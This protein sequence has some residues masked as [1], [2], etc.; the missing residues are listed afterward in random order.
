MA[1]YT[2]NIYRSNLDS[3]SEWLYKNLNADIDNLCKTNVMH[4]CKQ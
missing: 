2:H 3:V 4:K 1:L